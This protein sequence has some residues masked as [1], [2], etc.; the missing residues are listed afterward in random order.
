MSTKNLLRIV[1][2]LAVIIGFFMPWIHGFKNLSGL[3]LLTKSGLWESKGTMIIRFSIVLVPLLPLIVLFNT[4]NKK[5]SSGLLRS[6]AFIIMTVYAVFFLV[7]IS[8][9]DADIPS[10]ER[11]NIFQFLRI[12]FYLSFIGSLLLMFVKD[13]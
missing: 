8:T 1:F 2:C 5:P 12:G 3:D 6:G 13:E 7:G 9:L 10:E 11:S 4:I